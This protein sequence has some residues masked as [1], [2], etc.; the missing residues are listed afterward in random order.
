MHYQH[1]DRKL[2]FLLTSPTSQYLLVTSGNET[3]KPKTENTAKHAITQ[4]HHSNGAPLLFDR[5]RWEFSIVQVMVTLTGMKTSIVPS[6]VKQPRKV[7]G[8]KLC[9]KIPGCPRFTH[10][11]YAPHMRLICSTKSQLSP[12]L[13][14]F[15]R[16]PLRHSATTRLTNCGDRG[17]TFSSSTDPR[18]GPSA[19]LL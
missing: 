3:K 2:K 15:G 14:G 10:T 6:M 7:G 11:I 17:L 5:Q 18:E 13:T 8:Q 1:V 4:R 12:L 16:R 19:M 9:S